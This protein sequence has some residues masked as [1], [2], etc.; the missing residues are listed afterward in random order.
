MQ[1]ANTSSRLAAV[2]LRAATG[3]SGTQAPH[4]LALTRSF[5]LAAVSHLL[6][7][8]PH[9]PASHWVCCNRAG[10]AVAWAASRCC[11][12]ER[13][14]ARRNQA[15]GGPCTPAQP[16]P[17]PQA[18]HVGS[19]IRPGAC[20]HA[21]LLSCAPDT[22]LA[23]PAACNLDPQHAAQHAAWPSCSSWI[24]FALSSIPAHAHSSCGSLTRPAMACC[25]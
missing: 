10:M 21:I 24:A 25:R 3:P 13:G 22:R 6:L 4:S 8:R 14:G 15:P 19:S 16:S 9:V 18:S 17:R 1:R 11:A 20:L 2:G 12:G 5:S 7:I 23:V